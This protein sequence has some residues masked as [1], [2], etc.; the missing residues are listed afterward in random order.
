MKWGS[1]G[2]ER[3]LTW[4]E[5]GIVVR[6]VPAT[7]PFPFMWQFRSL[8]RRE[9]GSALSPIRLRAIARRAQVDID[10]DESDTFAWLR[11]QHRGLFFG[12]SRAQI[13][14]ARTPLGIFSTLRAPLRVSGPQL[15]PGDV[16]STG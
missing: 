1:Y 6:G 14:P 16:R 7:I 3:E 2:R 10:I 15:R 12:T 5:R 11:G 8:Q 4:D 13:A 9:D